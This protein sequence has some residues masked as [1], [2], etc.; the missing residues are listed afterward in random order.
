MPREDFDAR[1]GVRHPTFPK[2]EFDAS[3]KRR[4][5]AAAKRL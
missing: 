5:L 4:R 1:L 2:I 3:E